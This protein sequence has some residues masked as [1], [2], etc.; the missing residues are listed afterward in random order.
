[1]G[2]DSALPAE[3]DLSAEAVVDRER[4][5][6]ALGAL[7]AYALLR[8]GAGATVAMRVRAAEDGR[9]AVAIVGAGATLPRESLAQLF[10]PFDVAPTGARAPAGL[11]LAVGVARRVIELHGGT[12]RAEAV[13]EGGLLVVVELPGRMRPVPAPGKTDPSGLA[14]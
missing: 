13:P 12:A 7:L 14:G 10:D 2:P 8:P 6:R 5:A 1:M 4:V 9:V 11:G 3:G